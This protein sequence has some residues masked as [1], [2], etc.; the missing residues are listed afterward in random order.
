VLIT[1]NVER[2]MEYVRKGSKRRIRDDSRKRRLSPARRRKGQ[3]S[4]LLKENE[5]TPAPEDFHW[6][7]ELRIK[8]ASNGLALETS[9]AA[10]VG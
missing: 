3:K 7:N 2:G 8:G 10:L 5:K 1:G 9:Q 4:K 6:E